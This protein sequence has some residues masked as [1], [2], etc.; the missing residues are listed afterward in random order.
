MQE[1]IH[2][3][4]EIIEKFSADFSGHDASDMQAKP[5]ADKWSKKEVIGHLIDSAHTNLRRFIVGQYENKYP[6]R[7]DQDFWVKANNYQNTPVDDIILLWK[8]I[9]Q[10]ICTVLQ[11]MPAENYRK[12]VNTG[13][14]ET[15][16][17]HSLQWL[18]A[19][20]VKHLKHHIN[21]VIPGSFHVSYP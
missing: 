19:D 6:I 15:P 1:T 10:R 3:L 7:Y 13:K 14:E 16:E 2:E 9:N 20:Y 8:A 12:E 5:L 21:Q 18:A 4:K 17:M 11:N